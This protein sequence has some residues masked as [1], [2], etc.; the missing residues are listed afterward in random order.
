[1]SSDLDATTGLLRPAGGG[2]L[3]ADPSGFSMEVHPDGTVALRDAP[4]LN[5]HLALPSVRQL[6]NGLSAWYHGDKGPYGAEGE[7]TL[8]KAIQA[9]GGSTTDPDDRSKTVIVPVLAGGFDVTDALMRGHG[10]DPYA[11]KKLRMLDATRDERVQLGRRHRAAQLARTGELSHANLEAVWARAGDVAARRRAL[12]TLW[13]ECAEAGEPEVIAAGAAA[14]ALIVGFVRA[15]L[16]AGSAEAYA[17]DELAG[18]NRGRQSRAV[19]A[20]YD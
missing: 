4:N 2:A 20:P 10:Q 9:S 18:L 13:D 14:R 11:A 8:G 1:M 15:R 12:F 3:R 19:F 17:P 6:G 16:P 5:V 7:P